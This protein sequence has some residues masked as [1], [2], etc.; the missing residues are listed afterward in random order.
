MNLGKPRGEIG[1]TTIEKGKYIT[2]HF[3]I[4]LDEFEKSWTGLFIWMNENGYKKTEGNPFE[5]YQ[6]NFNDHPEKKCVVDLY[7]PI[8]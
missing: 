4:S 5:I 6:N 3:E 1:L 7:I 8:E 2:G